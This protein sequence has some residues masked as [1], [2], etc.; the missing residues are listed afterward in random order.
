MNIIFALAGE[1]KRFKKEGFLVPKFFLKLN[2]KS[3]IENMVELF[4][5]NV[6]KLNLS[7]ITLF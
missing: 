6:L 2:S 1:S 4:D 3:L 5:D 7:I